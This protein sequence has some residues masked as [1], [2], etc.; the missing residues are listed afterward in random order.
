MEIKDIYV[1]VDESGL[2]CCPP[3]SINGDISAFIYVR[4][5]T[6]QGNN[7]WRKF[8]NAPEVILPPWRQ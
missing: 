6:H 5:N 8:V 7:R 3:V 1:T 2:S 4:Q